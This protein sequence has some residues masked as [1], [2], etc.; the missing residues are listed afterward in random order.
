MANSSMRDLNYYF[1][2]SSF[3]GGEISEEMQGRNDFN[4]YDV[5]LSDAT[6]MYALPQGGIYS[7]AGTELI[8]DFDTNSENI[9]LIPFQF[10]VDQQYVMLFHNDGYIYFFANRGYLDDGSGG[11]YRIA[12]TL[13]PSD[14]GELDY[15]Q[16]ADTVFL[17]SPQSG[18]YKIERY[19]ERDFRWSNYEAEAGAFDSLNKTE[20]Y[21]ST[22]TTTTAVDHTA[23]TLEVPSFTHNDYGV[24]EVEEDD[25]ISGLFN[26]IVE[27]GGHYWQAKENGELSETNDYNQSYYS[28]T[29]NIDPNS[30]ISTTLEYKMTM[31]YSRSSYQSGDSGSGFYRT[32]YVYVISGRIVIEGKVSSDSSNWQN[33][34]TKEVCT[35]TSF[36]S[37]RL[38]TLREGY[39][40]ILGNIMENWFAYGS[41]SITIPAGYSQIRMYVY[42]YISDGS[43]YADYN[44]TGANLY[45]CRLNLPAW[46]EYVTTYD[47]NTLVSSEPLF[48]DSDVG[49]T[50]MVYEAVP[51]HETHS[52][53]SY[54]SDWL[55]CK[56]DWSILMSGMFDGTITIQVSYDNRQTAE[57]YKAWSL[58]DVSSF[59]DSGTIDEFC[60]IR[61]VLVEDP[62][63]D[64]DDYDGGM[65]QLNVGS[66][67][68]TVYATI[69][70][71]KSSTEVVIEFNTNDAQSEWGFIDAIVKN[72]DYALSVWT[73]TLGYPRA[74]TLFQDRLCFASSTS[75]PLNVWMSATGDYYNFRTELD[76]DEDD[77][78]IN[79]TLTSQTMNNIN[80][81]ISKNDLLGF[82]EGGVWK[83]NSRSQVTGLTADTVFA[84]QQNYEGSKRIAPLL[85]N[86]HFIYVLDMGSTLKDLRYDYNS[87]SYIGDDLT[88]LAKH[89]FEG[90]TDIVSWT[91]AQE[92]DS[93]VYVVRNDGVLI[94]L[95]YLKTQEV[96]AFSKHTTQGLFKAVCAIRGE[97]RSDVYVV[98]NRGGKMFMEIFADR[99][100]LQAEE[101]DFIF[102]DCMM[103]YDGEPTSHLSG[104]DIL[105]GYTVQIIADGVEMPDQPVIDGQIDIP[106]QASLIL[107]GLGYNKTITTLDLET[108]R[109]DGTGFNRKHSVGEVSLLLKDSY[110]GTIEVDEDNRSHKF[111]GFMP[112]PFG[113]PIYMQSGYF[114]ASCNANWANTGRVTIS[115]SRPVPL[116]ILALNVDIALGG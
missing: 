113:E 75:Y 35:G 58:V 98:V 105:E 114:K 70:A 16:S 31:P 24:E 18:M 8:W 87:D 109:D 20:T 68:H 63:D 2:Q 92:P 19:G 53:S 22:G 52:S 66:F 21:I 29:I 80:N 51:A 62:P 79:V 50:I 96:Y 26:P 3:A 72:Y 64:D 93:L 44:P 116:N 86:D 61:L 6:N 33:I 46:T 99:R 1:R 101:D 110:V 95:T 82:S 45:Y 89:L 78:A 41:E 9:Q 74:V 43:E 115:N 77:A 67:L 23:S 27:I 39:A 91:Y 60:Y 25:G 111:S 59:E 40:S 10:N 54:T 103:Y 13:D 14:I 56:G 48:E 69:T 107:V 32:G 90:D 104:L 34:Y 49:R 28:S 36:S 12:H 102:M 11:I 55:P 106:R 30:S 76:E 112:Q 15:V 100:A 4:K 17:T 37:G 88:L 57:T 97:G 42:F 38:N 85:I 65:V 81:L 83:I 71:V 73:P 108:Q 47:M 7:R 84:S 5:S 94:T